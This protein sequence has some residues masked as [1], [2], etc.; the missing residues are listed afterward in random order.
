MQH[1]NLVVAMSLVGDCL[2]TFYT[3]NGK[4]IT[5][6]RLSKPRAIEGIGRESWLMSIK[7]MIGALCMMN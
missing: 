2:G 6:I 4:I 1:V 5:A 3:E 7:G